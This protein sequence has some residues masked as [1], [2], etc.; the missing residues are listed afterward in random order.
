MC[1]QLVHGSDRQPQISFLPL[2]KRSLS[3][4]RW[5]ETTD[6]ATIIPTCGRSYFR[7]ISVVSVLVSW[8]WFFFRKRDF[9]R[10]KVLVF[11]ACGNQDCPLSNLS[12]VIITIKRRA[13]FFPLVTNAWAGCSLL[14]RAEE[15]GR[16]GASAALRQAQGWAGAV[17]ARLHGSA[18]SP[19]SWPGNSV[20]TFQFWSCLVTRVLMMLACLA[21]CE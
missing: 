13:G 6:V 10:S 20:P 7:L 18:G 21:V 2:L 11:K 19:R 8:E 5:H 3:G 1:R 14:C 16:C 17:R 15:E 12:N 9:W 4:G